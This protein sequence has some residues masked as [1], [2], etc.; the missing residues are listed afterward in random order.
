MSI[1]S[2]GMSI[3]GSARTAVDLATG[4]EQRHFVEKMICDLLEI[5]PK[6]PVGQSSPGWW[7]Q[8]WGPAARRHVL[9]LVD[10]QGAVPSRAQVVAKDDDLGERLI[11]FD[12]GDDVYQ[13]LFP[14]EHSS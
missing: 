1:H 11:G 6:W 2:D 7:F 12:G 9:I 8:V 13:R 4:A 14:F 5:F 3:G 10:Q